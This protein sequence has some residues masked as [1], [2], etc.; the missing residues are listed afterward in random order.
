M[1]KIPNLKKRKKKKKEK[2]TV[3]RVRPKGTRKQ[4]RSR[5]KWG[6][7]AALAK[8]TLELIAYMGL[9]QHGVE[10]QLPRDTKHTTQRVIIG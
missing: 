1:K 7:K 5:P 9:W 3:L 6:W 8:P 10:P 2:K 4:G